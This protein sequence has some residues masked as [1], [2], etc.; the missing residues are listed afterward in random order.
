MPFLWAT[1]RFMRWQ[2][3]RLRK[4]IAEME[5]RNENLKMTIEEIEASLCKQCQKKLPMKDHDICY[6]CYCAR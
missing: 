5:K 1:S 6:A 4:K 2:N 3:E